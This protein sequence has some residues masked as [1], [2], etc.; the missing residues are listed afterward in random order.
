[1]NFNCLKAKRNRAFCLLS[2]EEAEKDVA[3]G[4]QSDGCNKV[5][6]FLRCSLLLR[7]LLNIRAPE[8]EKNRPLLNF[9][10]R[11]SIGVGLKNHSVTYLFLIH[12]GYLARFMEGKIQSYEIS[13]RESSSYF[14]PFIPHARYQARPQS[15]IYVF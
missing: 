4:D 8:I 6:I 13:F 10:R 9:S 14:T 12:S 15:S 3:V 11:M 7:S 2:S 1:M 5:C